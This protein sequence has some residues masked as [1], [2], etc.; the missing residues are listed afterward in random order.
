MGWLAVALFSGRVGAEPAKK[1]LAEAGFKT[2]IQGESWL[3]FLWFVPRRKAGVWLAVA[4]DEFERAE[5]FLRSLDPSHPALAQAI[6]CPECKSLRVEYPQFA[7]HSLLT[8]LAL[9]VAAQTGLVER[10]YF[11]EHCHFTW[12]RQGTRPRRDRPH[13]A[14]Y[15]FIEGVEQTFQKARPPE[16]RRE[17]A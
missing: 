6:R 15:Y 14:P 5:S 9:G 12:P 8:N 1:L 7:E 16:E 10:D 2:K 13:L 11:C 4:A 3:Q 17:A